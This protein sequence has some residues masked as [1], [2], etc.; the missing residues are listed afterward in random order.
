MIEIPRFPKLFPDQF[1]KPVGAPL[2]GVTYILRDDFT[3][4]TPAGSLNGTAPTPGPGGN[5]V[6]VDSAGT[7]LSTS[8]GVLNIGAGAIGDPRLNYS[9]TSRVAGKCLMAKT[10]LTDLL[11]AFRPI[12]WD[13]GQTGDA[14]YIIGVSTSALGNELLTISFGGTVAMNDLYV[15]M[16]MR[17]TG[18]FYLVKGGGT[19]VDWTLLWVSVVG[20]DANLYPSIIG[21]TKTTTQDYIRCAQLGAP[22][23]TDDGIATQILAGAR[24]A[25]DSWTAEKDFILYFTVTTLPTAGNI[26]IRFRA[27]DATNYHQL[28]IDSTGAWDWNIVTA[29]VPADKLNGSGITAGMRVGIRALGNAV[30]CPHKGSVTAA[31]SNTPQF[32][33][34]TGGLLNDLGTGG[35]VTRIEVWPVSLSG[36]ALSQI[37]AMNHEV[38]S[39]FQIN[40]ASMPNSPARLTIPNG[41]VGHNANQVVHPDICRPNPSGKWNG[42]TYWMAI[43]P[44]P[45]SNTA[46]ENPFILVSDDMETWIEPPGISNP[47][48]PFEV[49][50]IHSDPD[51]YYDVATDTLYVLYR[52][53]DEATYDKIMIRT[54]TDGVTW[55]DK[56]EILTGAMS[57][58]ISP[59]LIWNG[60]GFELYVIQTA[61]TAGHCVKRTC[62]TITGVWSAGVTVFSRTPYSDVQEMWHL[63]MYYEAVN[64]Y[65]AML[66]CHTTGDY[67]FLV[68]SLDGSRWLVADNPLMYRSAGGWDGKWIYRGSLGIRTPTGFDVIYSAKSDNG[69]GDWGAGRTQLTI[70]TL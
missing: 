23:N 13:V 7:K 60:T 19:Y 43:C 36:N 37:S 57:T 61:G 38:V 49:G 5:R 30:Y 11:N 8:L 50:V 29:G 59:S 9:I 47:I 10:Y 44:Y 21:N 1:S 24:S 41:E 63:D 55:S 14:N 33:T 66:T 64:G 52:D 16:V 34:G 15:A 56:T 70:P 4:T 42:Y 31:T 17:G 12:G 22:W 26:E 68:T 32:N 27:Q 54:S 58:L 6:V 25:G 69:A 48:A 67:M 35:A 2:S 40:S 45:E 20:T 28:L 62:A 65:L 3:D 46:K 53:T 39:G 51:I 18:M